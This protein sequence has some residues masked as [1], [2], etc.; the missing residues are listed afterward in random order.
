M[1]MGDTHFDVRV[2]PK[3]SKANTP[4]SFA[5][6][7][8]ARDVLDSIFLSNYLF[9]RL[10]KIEP[11]HGNGKAYQQA[12]SDRVQAWYYV[13]REFEAKNKGT[14]T[15]KDITGVS[16]L[17]IHYCCLYITIDISLDASQCF[18]EIPA[19]SFLNIVTLVETLWRNKHST[20]RHHSDCLTIH[21]TWGSLDL[22]FM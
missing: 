16:L 19:S 8:E 15:T 11:N 22:C 3:H 13:N 14:L 5:T 20:A 7:T 12:L 17:E 18:L 9:L 6:V 1:F 4:T 10:V 21:L 2:I